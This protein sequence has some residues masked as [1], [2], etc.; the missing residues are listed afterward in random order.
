MNGR[1]SLQGRRGHRF[2][3]SALI[4]VQSFHATARLLGQSLLRI[5]RLVRK[6]FWQLSHDKAYAVLLVILP[7]MLLL[8]VVN[9]VN[10][11]D[12]S[13]A[14][15]AV[16]DQD[17][18][19]LSREVITT[20]ENTG[21]TRVK[22]W[23][24]RLEDGQAA[25]S[26]GEIVALVAIPPGF[27]RDITTPQKQIELLAVVD[28]TKI[29]SASVALGAISGAVQSFTEGR[30]QASGQSVGLTLQTTRYYDI[31]RA[32]DPVSSQLAFLVNQIVLVVAGMGL[33]REREMGTLEQLMVTPLRRAELLLGKT[34]PALL[35]GMV[36]FWALWGAGRLVWGVPMRGSLLLLFA[37]SVLFILAA[38][39]WGLFLSAQAANQQQATQLIF[40]QVLVDL[41]LCGYVVP[42]QNLPPFLVWIAELLPLRHYMECV[43]V[44]ML[45]GGGLSAVLPHALAL[46]AL[47]AVIWILNTIVLKQKLD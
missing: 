25:L 42:V 37:L 44:V 15:I 9:V 1:P 43:R 33:A 40:V 11:G 28:G 30:A 45:R 24:T 20:I 17:R 34:M 8:L 46:V 26:S 13:V 2:L 22:L 23:L 35:I 10:E 31:S 32:H 27:Q 14:D 19:S 47:N 5:L 3:L 16:L 38:S 4:P 12:K 18:T 41:A 29:W 6:E 39:A 36:N 7:L 21:E